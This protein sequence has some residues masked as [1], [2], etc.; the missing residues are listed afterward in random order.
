MG[1]KKN[2]FCFL[3]ILGL[4]LFTYS[5]AA[6]V[7]AETPLWDHTFQGAGFD[8]PFALIECSAGGFAFC[9]VTDSYG[10]GIQDAW[11]VRTDDEGT[12]LWNS[13]VGGGDYDQS[14]ALVETSDGG[15][16]LAGLTASYGG[17]GAGAWLIRTNQDGIH[18]WNR[19][20]ANGMS[21]GLDLV[22][23]GTGGFALLGSLVEGPDSVLWL[24][25]TD[26]NG[27]PLWNRTLSSRENP[28]RA[29]VECQN[30]GFAVLSR[31]RVG[32]SRYAWLIRT[33]ETGHHLWNATFGGSTRGLEVGYDL[34]EVGSGGF[35][36]TGSYRS[37]LWLV[38][39]DAMGLQLWNR[40]YSSDVAHLGQG[41]VECRD[42]GFA[43][44][45]TTGDRYSAQPDFLVTRTD[46]NGNHLWFKTFGG[47]L[48]DEGKAIV[49]TASDNFV[50]VGVT[51]DTDTGSRDAR[52]LKATDTAPIE[53]LS[54]L[55]YIAISVII[56]GIA[57]TVVISIFYYH[58]RK[59]HISCGFA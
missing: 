5:N 46:S 25:R 32:S 24:L 12:H 6:P 20:Y 43:I 11:L 52:L 39:S 23:C 38:R 26:A 53:P 58:H 13:T 57:A 4:L 15:F 27:I 35:A 7:I 36:F 8:M 42:G 49:Q 55:G 47:D 28:P 56:L 45:G 51:G 10:A 30:G 31:T 33:N 3:V 44:A 16:V 21:S 9:G 59:R 50:I 2:W 41:L 19:T 48:Y 1:L 17:N 14:T 18:L 37:G 29:L 40:S 34:V 22:E 54:L